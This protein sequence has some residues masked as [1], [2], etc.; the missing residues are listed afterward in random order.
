PIE[1]ASRSLG[2][3]AVGGGATR[4]FVGAL[5]DPH[6]ATRRSASLPGRRDRRGA[7]RPH[8]FRRALSALWAKPGVL[9]GTRACRDRTRPCTSPL[10]RPALRFAVARDADA[11]GSHGQCGES[12]PATCT[13]A[14]GDG[15]DGRPRARPGP[16]RVHFVLAT[17]GVPVPL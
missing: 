5:P 4:R 17:G 14:R 6:G 9:A 15:S 2:I 3:L 12:W 16:T 13:G 7:R 10:L 8:R 11:R 1:I